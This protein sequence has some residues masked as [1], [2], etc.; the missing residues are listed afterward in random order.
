MKRRYIYGSLVLLP[1]FV[2]SGLMLTT[3]EEEPL[4]EVFFEEDELLISAYLEEHRDDYSSLIRVLELADLKSTLNAT[5]IILSSLRITV[6]LKHSCN[7]RENL[8]WRNLMRN[9]C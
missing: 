2:L 1:L 9:T 8:P 6:H 7:N 4:E 5:A 3:C